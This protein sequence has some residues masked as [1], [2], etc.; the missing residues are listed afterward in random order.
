MSA[1]IRISQDLLFRTI[2]DRDDAITDYAA[3]NLSPARYA[4]MSCAVELN[5]DLAESAMFQTEL[6]ACLINE[7]RPVPLSPLL[8]G[9]TLAKLSYREADEVQNVAANDHV[10]RQT[11]VAPRPLRDLMGGTGLRDIQWK[12]LIPGMAIHDVLGNRRT[13]EGDRLYLLKAKGGMRM[14]EHSHNGEEWTLILN[15]AYTVEGRTFRRGDLHIEDETKTHS[16]TIEEGEDCICL[17]MTEGPL[18]MKS[19]LPKLIQKVVGI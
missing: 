5:P 2:N 18:V 12:S 3:G 7:I 17:V 1:P 15:G 6:A 10:S 11:R 13:E 8:I 9:E 16:P 4:L 19:W 14:P